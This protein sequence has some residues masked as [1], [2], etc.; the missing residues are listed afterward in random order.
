[1]PEKWTAVWRATV[2][3]ARNDEVD[4]CTQD[5]QCITVE[6]ASPWDVPRALHSKGVILSHHQRS[7]IKLNNMPRR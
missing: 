6:E 2:D 3:R 5:G 1:M 4:M 7:I